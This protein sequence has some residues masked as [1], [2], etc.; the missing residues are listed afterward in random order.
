MVDNGPQEKLQGAAQP[1]APASSDRSTK[2]QRSQVAT[3]REGEGGAAG[4]GITSGAKRQ[5]KPTNPE[6]TRNQPPGRPAPVQGLGGHAPASYHPRVPF[7]LVEEHAKVQ[8][9]HERTSIGLRG[10]PSRSS[11]RR[12]GRSTR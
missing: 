6:N 9:S 12:F 5:V 10:L 8:K 3:V 7:G 2:V 1:P 11:N 4:G